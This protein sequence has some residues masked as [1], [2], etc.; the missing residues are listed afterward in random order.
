[1]IGNCEGNEVIGG[2]E[3]MLIVFCVVASGLKFLTRTLAEPSATTVKV[4]L[5]MLKLSMGFP[6]VAPM[7]PATLRLLSAIVTVAVPA[8]AFL[9]MLVATVTVAPFVAITDP[10]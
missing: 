4:Q 10:V 1:M 2:I 8:L 7:V 6:F 3:L 9:K 5:V